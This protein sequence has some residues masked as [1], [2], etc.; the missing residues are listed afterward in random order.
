MLVTILIAIPAASTI[1]WAAAAASP[2]AVAAASPNAPTILAAPEMALFVAPAPLA[3]LSV[4]S[5]VFSPNK[6]SSPKL[7]VKIPSESN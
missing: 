4:K 5:K 6:D 1:P 7:L 3:T 2:A